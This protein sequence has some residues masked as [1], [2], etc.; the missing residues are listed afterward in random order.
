[1]YW[2]I[3]FFIN[4]YYFETYLMV[5]RQMV[6]SSR[7]G[8]IVPQMRVSKTVICGNVVGMPL[9]EKSRLTMF[10]WLTTAKHDDADISIS[11]KTNG[12]L[13]RL[14]NFLEYNRNH[15]SHFNHI[16][17]TIVKWCGVSS[18][19]LSVDILHQHGSFQHQNLLYR[20][21]SLPHR[22]M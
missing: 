7:V 12:I 14:R 20:Y 6:L 2:G 4:K 18:S 10:S 11:Y 8:K 13:L 16:Y 1:M 3:K 15:F 19:L 9:L 17:I 21:L 22:N 5:S